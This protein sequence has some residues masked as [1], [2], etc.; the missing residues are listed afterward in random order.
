VQ[1]L[2]PLVEPYAALG[3]THV[4]GG[5]G[6]VTTAP[7]LAATGNDAIVDWVVVELRAK[8]D[9]SIVVATR[10]AL[11]QRDGDVVAASGTTAVTFNAP[12]GLYHVAVR[13]RNHLG[14]MSEKLLPVGPSVR[15]WDLSD[16]SVPLFGTDA[17]NDVLGTDVL[18]A[19][20]T[21]NDGVLR[22]VGDGNDRDPILSVIGG[23]VPTAIMPG[24]RV[25]DVNLDGVT[26]YVG[27]ANDRD[28]VLQ[29]IGGSVPTNT[30]VEQLP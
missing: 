7:V 18:W 11:L 8:N 27:D 14:V 4:G 15:S 30:R 9:P 12:L 24:Y 23:S 26:K 20:N 5:G 10:S 1:G 25:E 22:Y 21:L 13:H 29:N 17:V 28:P 2:V 3:Y 6:E 19:G 16:G